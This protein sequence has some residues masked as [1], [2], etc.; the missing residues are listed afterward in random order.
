MSIR[1]RPLERHEVAEAARLF[2]LAFGTYLGLPDPT[3]FAKGAD[4]IGTRRRAG[5][6]VFGAFAGTQLLGSNVVTRWGS[7]G[8]F[9]P[10]TVHPAHWDRGIGKRLLEPV[11]EAFAAWGVERAGLFTF[12]GSA[13]HLA[14]YQ[15]HDFW[16]QHLMA[17]MAKAT[18]APTALVPAAHDPSTDVG[19]MAD[20]ADEARELTERLYPG[21]DVTC[22]ID[23]VLEQRLGE[24][25]A[26]RD[27]AG[28]LAAFAIVH[29]GTGSEAGDDAA[30]V[31]FA[32]ARAGDCTHLDRLLLECEAVAARRGVSALVVGVSTA[33][34]AAYRCVL[35]RGYR[36]QTTGVAMQ[37]GNEPG[38]VSPSSLVLGDWR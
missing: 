22:E 25:V 12:P 16:P 1:I 21:L 14:L 19:A 3:H 8:F 18:A 34:S 24:I 2:R 17:I 15:K 20:V 35:E 37:R 30:L 10:L 33:C 36:I 4:I 28:S 13:K 7:F 38:Y 9:G 31:K 32:A 23:A 6:Q 29:L 26:V 11:R 5:A 27:A